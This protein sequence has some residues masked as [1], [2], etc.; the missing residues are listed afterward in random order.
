MKCC[1]LQ[2]AKATIL[3]L[4]CLRQRCEPSTLPDFHHTVNNLYEN[5]SFKKENQN[6][7][8]YYLLN[9]LSILCTNLLQNLCFHDY[10][11]ATCFS[12]LLRLSRGR[13]LFMCILLSH[14]LSPHSLLKKLSFIVSPAP[15]LQSMMTTVYSSD[16]KHTCSPAHSA[17]FLV[18]SFRRQNRRDSIYQAAA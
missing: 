12:V 8:R 14:I 6:Y 7:H 9:S 1:I 3:S 15:A 18:W 16:F 17:F 5:T 13:L 10:M 11:S 4:N 2:S